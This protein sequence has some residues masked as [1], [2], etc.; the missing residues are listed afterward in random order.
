MNDRKG[1]RAAESQIDDNLR[2]IFEQDVEQDLPERLRALLED[3]DRDDAENDEGESG[4]GN[5]SGGSA[6]GGG[7]APGADRSA[8][9]VGAASV[10]AGRALA[11]LVAT[12][13][14]SAAG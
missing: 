1:Q 7:G 11:A 14:R 4:G 9:S 3:L 10:P 5:G 2:R 6:Q 8:R 13:M 12:P